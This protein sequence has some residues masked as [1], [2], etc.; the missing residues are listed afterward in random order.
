MRIAAIGALSAIV[1][2]DALRLLICLMQDENPHIVR[3][4]A[5]ALEKSG[6]TGREA[7]D[8]LSTQTRAGSYAAEVISVGE[9][10]RARKVGASR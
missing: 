10:E 2:D 1:D 6:P 5:T 8:H 7:L 9:L 4:A 3:A